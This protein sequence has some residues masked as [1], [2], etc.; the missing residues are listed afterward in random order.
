MY[1]E[2]KK[3]KAESDVPQEVVAKI[4]GTMTEPEQMLGPDVSVTDLERNK[5]VLGG[6]RRFERRCFSEGG[7]KIFGTSTKPNARSRCSI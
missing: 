5:G 3:R 1:E 7:H 6:V 4:L 2:T